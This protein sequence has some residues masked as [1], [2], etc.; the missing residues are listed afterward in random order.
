IRACGMALS[1]TRR[2]VLPEY[3]MELGTRRWSGTRVGHWQLPLRSYA[4]S[5]TDRLRR[6][7]ASMRTVLVCSQSSAPIGGIQTILAHLTRLLPGHDWRM[8][9]GLALGNRFHD[10]V[11][12]CT[13]NPELNTLTMDGRTGT[14]EGRVQ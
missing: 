5:T 6:F 11:A 7:Q 13:K 9:V 8:V 4:T 2:K 10:P 3:S 14:R 12:F 1:P